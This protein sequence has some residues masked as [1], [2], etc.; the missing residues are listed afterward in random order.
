MAAKQFPRHKNFSTKKPQCMWDSRLT[1]SWKQ[2]FLT[3]LQCVPLPLPLFLSCHQQWHWTATQVHSTMK[4]S[5]LIRPGMERTSMDI[6]SKVC[7]TMKPIM[8]PPLF[9]LQTTLH[10]ATEGP[11]WT[12]QNTAM[13]LSKISSS[14]TQVTSHCW[15]VGKPWS[16]YN[17]PAIYSPWQTR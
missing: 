9:T 1:Q 11:R 6:S 7:L 14:P 2:F 17:I 12:I 5:L 10:G 16:S 4:P 15:V 3:D 8:K 13:I